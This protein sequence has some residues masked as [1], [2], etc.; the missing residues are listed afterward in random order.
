MRLYYSSMGENIE[1][2]F[3]VSLFFYTKKK[4]GVS[5]RIQTEYG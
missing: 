3:W 1:Q 4:Y 5:L 2:W